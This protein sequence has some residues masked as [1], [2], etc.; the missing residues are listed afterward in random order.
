MSQVNSRIAISL[1]GF[2]AGP[3][4][5]LENPV[6]EGGERLHE[7]MF[8]TAS[9]RR[10][11]GEGGGEQNADSEVLDEVVKDIGAYIMGRNMFAPGRGEWD[12]GWKGWWGD[13]PP[14][15]VPVYVLTHYPREPLP[16]EGGTTFYFVTDGIDSAMRQARAA[17]GA[18]NVHVAGGARTIQQYLAAREIDELYLHLVPI[19]LGAGERLLEDVGDLRLEPVQVVSSP[20]VTH[21]KYRV[22][23]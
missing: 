8:D 15:H 2:V 16:M 19:I 18:R 20:R 10:Q 4:Q 17:A 9:W 13:D 1:D 22:L 21:L 3:N 12:L 5:G 7:W 14:Y 6:G 11:Q 23:R